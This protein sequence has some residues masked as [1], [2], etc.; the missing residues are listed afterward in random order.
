MTVT[1]REMMWVRDEMKTPVLSSSQSFPAYNSGVP[2]PPGCR[3]HAF[4]RRERAWSRVWL[5]TYSDSRRALPVLHAPRVAGASP[6]PCAQCHAAHAFC[7]AALTASAGVCRGCLTL[8][9]AWTSRCL[10][11]QSLASHFFPT[12]SRR[13]G[14]I[15]H[16]IGISGE[17]RRTGPSL[18]RGL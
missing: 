7:A 5:G 3:W 17:T 2:F 10:C 18:T 16:R 15:M 6:L 14:T 13:I 8:C 11:A 4:W 9:G 1:S 12:S